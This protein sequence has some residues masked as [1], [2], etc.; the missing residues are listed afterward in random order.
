VGWSIELSA[1]EQSDSVV[2]TDATEFG[3]SGNLLERP[4]PV[5][6]KRRRVR[7][8][9][10]EHDL[11][12]LVVNPLDPYLDERFPDAELPVFWGNCYSHSV[13]ARRSIPVVVCPVLR[14][15]PAHYFAVYLGYHD[16]SCTVVDRVGDGCAEFLG[17]GASAMALNF[18]D[19]I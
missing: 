6:G 18:A 14:R 5:S 7:G 19:A 11:V 3:S 1:E 4:M 16:L 12:G 8:V 9:C 17:K 2:E 13:V 15:S 10:E